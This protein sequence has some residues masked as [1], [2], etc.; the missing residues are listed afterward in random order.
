MQT[1]HY[2]DGRSVP[3]V[4]V[5]WEDLHNERAGY[6][7][8]FWCDS[9][10]GTSGLPVVGYCEAGGSHRTIKGAAREAQRRHPGEPIYRN[11]RQIA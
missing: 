11:G 3:S 1:I 7:R 4:I 8:A 2:T 5:I 10:A 9:P 6:Y